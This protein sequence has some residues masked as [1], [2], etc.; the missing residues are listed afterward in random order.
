VL[1]VLVS[2]LGRTVSTPR[3]PAL[4]NGLGRTVLTPRLPTP[5]FAAADVWR[6]TLG[7]TATIGRGPSLVIPSLALAM[8]LAASGSFL[9]LAYRIE[10]GSR[11]A[12]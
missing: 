3:L 9:L 2:G 6:P 5:D 11:P 4:V 7:W 8:L 10:R 1:P 12:W